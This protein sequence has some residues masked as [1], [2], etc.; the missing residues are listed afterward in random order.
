[1]GPEVRG[2]KDGLTSL[3]CKVLAYGSKTNSRIARFSVE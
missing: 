3:D 2:I 1:M